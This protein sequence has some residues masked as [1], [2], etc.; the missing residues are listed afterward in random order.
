MRACV[1]T[2]KNE[3]E[4]KEIETPKIKEDELL[5]EIK[6]CGICSSDFNRVFGDSAYFYP[7]V[8]GHEFAGKITK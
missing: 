2:N 3:I 1:L 6:A 8:L 5:I 7:L 4:Y